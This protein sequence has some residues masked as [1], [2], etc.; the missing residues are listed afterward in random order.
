MSAEDL[1]N[2]QVRI[3]RVLVPATSKRALVAGPPRFEATHVV[4]SGAK[5]PA[6]FARNQPSAPLARDQGL[7]FV[8][9]IKEQ[10]PEEA[11]CTPH[12]RDRH[13]TSQHSLPIVEFDEPLDWELLPLSHARPIRD[14]E[15]LVLGAEYHMA[16]AIVHECGPQP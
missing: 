7:A 1:L 13:G 12:G 11:A 2:R 15:A 3:L 14:P 6:S 10:G 5:S 4:G 8:E 9:P 16:D